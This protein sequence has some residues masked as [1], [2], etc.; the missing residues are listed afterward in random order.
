[1]SQEYQYWLSLMMREC[2]KKDLTCL[3]LDQPTAYKQNISNE[4]KSRLWMTPPYQTYTLNLND[5]IYT[6]SKYNNW[7]KN[8]ITQNGLSFFKLSDKLEPNTT[9]FI[10]DCHYSEKGS[11]QVSDEVASYIML[12]LKLLL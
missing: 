12:N 2:K 5:L 4:L 10:D 11:K 8:E 7:L 3:F 9:H 1:M 6:S